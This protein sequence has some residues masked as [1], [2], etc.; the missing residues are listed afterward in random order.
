MDIREIK[1]LAI[2]LRSSLRAHHVRVDCIV[3]FGSHS[4]ALAHSQSDIDLAVISSDFGRDRFLEGSLLNRIAV[5]IHPDI[6]AIPISLLDFLDPLPI[7]PVLHE[8]KSTGTILI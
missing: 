1:Q 8:I 2:A 7:S 3:L 6:E 5:K 4:K